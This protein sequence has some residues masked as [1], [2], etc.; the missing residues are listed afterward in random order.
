MDNPLPAMFGAKADTDYDMM[1]IQYGLTPDPDWSLTI[2]TSYML[3]V[4]NPTG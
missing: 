4:Y 1:V 3:A 2:F